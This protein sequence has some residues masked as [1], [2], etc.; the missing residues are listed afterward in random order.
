MTVVDKTSVDQKT[1]D[2]T[3][4][5]PQLDRIEERRKKKRNFLF[6]TT[7]RRD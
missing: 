5:R 4:R 2:E 1:V 6:V 7:M 3:P